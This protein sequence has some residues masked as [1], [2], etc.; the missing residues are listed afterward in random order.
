MSVIRYSYYLI[1]NL[2]LNSFIFTYSRTREKADV[3]TIGHK[4]YY[5]KFGN[6]L[7]HGIYSAFTI[8]S[9]FV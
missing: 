1:F 3:T 2:L 8:Y 4:H 5:A 7:K 6:L 9:I